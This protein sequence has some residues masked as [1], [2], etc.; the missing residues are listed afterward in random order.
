MG[1][2][3]FSNSR[4]SRVTAVTIPITENVTI[5]TAN[6][7]HR[8]LVRFSSLHL[9][10]QVKLEFTEVCNRVPE[11]DGH[12]VLLLVLHQLDARAQARRPGE[13]VDVLERKHVPERL[14]LP[15]LDTLED[16]L[17]VCKPTLTL[18]LECILLT[19]DSNIL[20]QVVH[21]AGHA[22]EIDARDGRQDVHLNLGHGQHVVVDIQELELER[23]RLLF[24]CIL[25]PNVQKVRV[26]NRHAQGVSIGH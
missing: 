16:S 17:L 4:K 10:R 21:V 19:C 11:H 25:D 8:V 5:A 7:T 6:I 18:E 3:G 23:R 14:V 26:V 12:V 9:R 13:H 1:S 22:L 2:L 24:R 15:G 20:S